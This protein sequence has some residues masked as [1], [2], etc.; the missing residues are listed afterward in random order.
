M[1]PSVFAIVVNY[2]GVSDTLECLESLQDITYTNFHVLVVDNASS[3]KSVQIIK[4]KYPDVGVLETGSNLGYGGGN[5]KG[6]EHA[7]ECDAQFVLILNNDMVFEPSM[8]D[9]LVATALE[10]PATGMVCGK[11]FYFDRPDIIWSAGSAI[12]MRTGGPKLIGNGETD[13]G[14]HHQ[15]RQV[16]MID[17]CLLLVT[18]QLC[19]KVGL[20]DTTYFAYYEDVDWA[21][22]STRAGFKIIYTPEARAW[23][24]V[25]ASGTVN[26]ERSPF[27][28]Y[29]H[30]RNHLLFLSR[31]SSITLGKHFEM[32]ATV[33][34]GL[35]KTACGYEPALSRARYRGILDYYRG[36]FGYRV[37]PPNR[38]Q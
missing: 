17:G 1:K 27:Q 25:S 37:P 20:I 3:D 28:L 14:T 30:M 8:V 9:A 4:G 18:R 22:R 31:Y 34:F 29:Y 11:V 5:N 38:N 12:D 32:F 15:A 13:N 19:D 21:I 16:D 26:G 10:S 33:V 36:R 35:L 2:N 24:K 6:I 23:H 7:L